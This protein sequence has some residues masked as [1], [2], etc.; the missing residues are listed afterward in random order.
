MIGP[1]TLLGAHILI[2]EGCVVSKTVIGHNCCIYQNSKI[3]NSHLWNNVQV[4]SNASITDSIL[5]HNVIIQKNAIIGKG[6]IIG[7]GCII[8]ENMVLPDFT[9]ITLEKETENDDDFDDF[10]IEDESSGQDEE[11]NDNDDD[12]EEDS[13]DTD[14]VTDHNVVGRDGLGRVWH[15]PPTEFTEDDPDA[16]S[17]YDDSDNEEAFFDDDDKDE[18][19]FD[20][21]TP[22]QRIHSQSIG[23]DTSSLYKN[24]QLTQKKEG[25]EEDDEYFSDEY[26]AE[27]TNIIEDTNNSNNVLPRSNTSN[28]NRTDVMLSTPAS[29]YNLDEDGLM[30]TGRSRGMDVVKELKA[31]CMEH[32]S[33]SPIEN[34]MI[35]LNGFKFSQNATF[36]DCVTGAIL[37]VMDRMDLVKGVT[38]PI[39]LCEKLRK[40]LQHWISLFTKMCH[41]IEEEKSILLALE[42][43]AVGGGDV[44]AVL[45]KAPS[46]RFLLQTIY[47]MD[48]VSE[49]AILEW[50]KKRKE[51]F[52]EEEKE[53]EE[54]D[55]KKKLFFQEPT[56][57]FLDWLEDDDDDDSD[58]G[59][60][61]EDDSD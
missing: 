18:T 34:L 24:R 4:H 41:S 52:E 35:E 46:F 20:I 29:T 7:N 21:A 43:A 11:D 58:S 61:S 17:D 1:G 8:G 10:G 19:V 33:T 59:S 60:G 31:M 47:D 45:S 36:S 16:D 14:N 53:G 30:I 3:K 38:T 42:N 51:D 55:D 15:P 50:S 54:N 44:G 9:R 48:V 2:Q 23:Y 56:Q 39:N 37:A 13:E 26:D 32:E 5:C 27:F 57:Q 28:Q 22:K 12:K 25:L 49:E 40:E 6:C